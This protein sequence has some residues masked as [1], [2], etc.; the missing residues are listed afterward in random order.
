MSSRSVKKSII[1]V[2]TLAFIVLPTQSF[3]NETDKE[4]SIKDLDFL[5]GTWEGQSTFLYPRDEERSPANETVKVSC[6]YVL[7]DT[8]IQCDTA[9]TNSDDRTR[10][11]RL[12]FNHNR[13]DEAYQVLFIYDN[14]P[15]HVSYLLNYDDSEDAYIG[16]SEFEDADG[17]T[18]EERVEWRLSEDERELRSAEFNHLASDPDDYWAKSFEY[19]WRKVD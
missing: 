13:L 6:A 14:W 15:R 18:G 17:E 5:I 9:W 12:H 3:A 7:K 10:T 16:L 4:P 19:V 8:Y 1:G 11:F 2:S